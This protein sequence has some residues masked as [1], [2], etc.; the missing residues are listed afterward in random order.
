M[1]H[2]FLFSQFFK[3]ID[4]KEAKTVF[5]NV[6]LSG[7]LFTSIVEHLGN[8][9][10]MPQPVRELA[11]LGW[12]LVGEKITPVALAEGFP[13][14][15][16]WCEIKHDFKGRGVILMPANWMD[17]YKDNPGYQIGA[18]VSMLSR[19]KD[20]WNLLSD[21]A[22]IE[23]HALEYEGMFLRYVKEEDKNYEFDDYQKHV[24]SKTSDESFKTFSLANCPPFPV[25]HG[26]NIHE[27]N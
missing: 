9:P 21:K 11:K 8:N 24:L 13:T 18:V 20:Y 22:K 1:K 3:P 15:S 26:G 14:L 27:N 6:Q 5:S 10:R 7:Q 23:T 16:F 2:D 25:P 12:N 17:M 4:A 19:S